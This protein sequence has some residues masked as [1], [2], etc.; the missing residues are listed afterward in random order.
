MSKIKGGIVLHVPP[1]D[2]IIQLLPL[3]Q[4]V[5]IVSSGK[6]LLQK[7]QDSFLLLA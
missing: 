3:I 1:F 2:K 7:I 5:V 6:L 4:A